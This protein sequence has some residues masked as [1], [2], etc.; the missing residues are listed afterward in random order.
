MLQDIPVVEPVTST[1]KLAT[2]P[3][4]LKMSRLRACTLAFTSGKAATLDIFS[5]SAALSRKLAMLLTARHY[6][7]DLI[8]TIAVPARHV[9]KGSETH[10]T[11]YNGWRSGQLFFDD[12]LRHTTISGVSSRSTIGPDEFKRFFAGIS[13]RTY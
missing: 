3:R 12:Q 4:F 11:P 10:S 13:S 5:H 7:M 2:D 1:R 8:P 6:A 9:P